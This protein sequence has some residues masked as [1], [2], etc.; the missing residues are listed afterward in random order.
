MKFF[1][2]RRLRRLLKQHGI[3]TKCHGCG[4][5]HQDS[6]TTETVYVDENNGHRRYR[7]TCGHCGAIGY[8]L[9]GAPVA[10]RVDGPVTS[11]LTGGSE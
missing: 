5:W 3:I 9:Y 11:E 2:R 8:W 10:I 7:V 1:G 6:E 4:N